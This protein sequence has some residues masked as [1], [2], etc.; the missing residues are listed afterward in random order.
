M[1]ILLASAFLVAFF[2]AVLFP[3]LSRA[4]SFA[5]LPLMST[6]PHGTSFIPTLLFKMM[7]FLS[8]C[9][10]NNRGRLGYCVHLLQL[11]FYSYLS[12]FARD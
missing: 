1:D 7:R 4:I 5:I 6:L 2:S 3:S 8:L 12:V 10:G 11:R 9:Q